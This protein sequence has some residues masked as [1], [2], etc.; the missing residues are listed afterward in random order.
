MSGRLLWIL[1]LGLTVLGAVWLVLFST[2]EFG[3]GLL[4]IWDVLALAYIVTGWLLLRRDLPVAA[5]EELTGPRW[6]TTLF[7]V[8]ASGSGLTAGMILIAKD[9][10]TDDS[11]RA[12]AAATILLSW[13]LLHTAFAQIYTRAFRA[14]GGLEFPECPAPQLTEFVYFSF[15]IG[16]SFAVS[17]VTVVNREMRR[18]VTAHSVLSFF[19]NAALVAIA[20]D[21]V[22]S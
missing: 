12:V 1:E 9:S 15:V 21:W 8:V 17:D 5:S 2:A 19:F 22:K 11:D 6:Y 10:V 16:T 20:I 14:T 3:V 4:L 13:L 7:A 18:R